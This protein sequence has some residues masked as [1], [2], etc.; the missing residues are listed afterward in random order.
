M[1]SIYGDGSENLLSLFFLKK[2]TSIACMNDG[3]LFVASHQLTP[4]AG[5]DNRLLLR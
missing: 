2:T 3:L 4:A 5:G 1:M